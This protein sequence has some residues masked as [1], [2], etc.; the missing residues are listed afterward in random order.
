MSNL[1]VSVAAVAL[2]WLAPSADAACAR[3]ASALSEGGCACLEPCSK[4]WPET[5]FCKVDSTCPSA[6]SAGFLQGYRDVCSNSHIVAEVDLHWPNKTS[7]L[8][9][10]GSVV[11]SL[12]FRGPPAILASPKPLMAP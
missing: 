8:F 12:Q 2:L 7:N 9:V 6:E 5:D 10:S 11:E 3:V 4:T 1:A